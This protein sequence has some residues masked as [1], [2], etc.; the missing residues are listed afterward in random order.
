MTPF[1]GRWPCAPG[2]MVPGAWKSYN[3]GPIPEEASVSM[4]RVTRLTDYATVVL[5]ALAARPGTVM[6][7]GRAFGRESAVPTPGWT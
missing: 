5:T 4:L 1:A 6:A 3:S 7:A 2:R